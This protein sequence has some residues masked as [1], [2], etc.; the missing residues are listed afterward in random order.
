MTKWFCLALCSFFDSGVQCEVTKTCLLSV[1]CLE[2]QRFIRGNRVE[3]HDVIT[4]FAVKLV[5][6]SETVKP[7]TPVLYTHSNKN[8]EKSCQICKILHAKSTSRNCIIDSVK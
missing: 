8:R 4:Q 6:C 2:T 7:P 3:I 1:A 5:H